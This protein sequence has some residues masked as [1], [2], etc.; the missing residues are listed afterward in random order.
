MTEP[1]DRQEPRRW[2]GSGRTLQ[3]EVVRYGASVWECLR[4]TTG[5]PME[6]SPF[7]RRLD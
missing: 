3:G 2:P 6:G 4:T 1:T 5:K 7:W